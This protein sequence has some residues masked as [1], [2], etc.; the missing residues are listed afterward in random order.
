MDDD[1]IFGDTLVLGKVLELIM[2]DG[3]CCGLHLNI[4]KTIFFWPNKD[5]RSR[6]GGD[7]PPNIA[8][9]LHGVKLLGR[10]ARVSL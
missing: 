10:P 7:F 9:P 3:S 6:L 5:P 1:T 8:R 2:K 4:N